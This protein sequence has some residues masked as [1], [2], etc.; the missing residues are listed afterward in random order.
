M[1]GCVA[2]A[3]CRSPSAGAVAVPHGV[4]A[5]AS[6]TFSALVSRHLPQMTASGL[7]LNS[8]VMP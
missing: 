6:L 3:P 1:L 5:L 8:F 2:L 4:A 7:V